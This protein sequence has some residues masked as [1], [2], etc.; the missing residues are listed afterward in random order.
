MK[1][2]STFTIVI[3]TCYVLGFYPLEGQKSVK[4]EYNI[5]EA[6][7][8]YLTTSK[9]IQ[10]MDING[11]PMQANVF[12]SLGCTI[13]Q[14]GRQD[15]NL[16]LEVKIDTLSQR[17]ESPQGNMG[18]VI[19]E[20]FGKTFT[21]T[22]TP[23]GKETDISEAAK[24]VFN[25]EGSGQSDLSQSF[26]DYFPDIPSVAMAPGY[27]WT[28]TDTVNAKTP[29]MTMIMVVK[30]ENK[31]EG[32]ETSGGK[33][34]VKI[35]SIVSGSRDMKITAQGNDI[36]MTGPF[37]GTGLLLFSTSDGYFIKHAVKTR[38]NGTLDITYPDSM[39]FPLVQD[40]DVVNEV[41]F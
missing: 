40:M 1:K 3:L 13:K 19:T 17:T 27:T 22:I 20:V 11:Q 30:A 10:T 8:K 38:L 26:Y 31:Y 21:M 15:G 33:E 25:V 18:G 36:R 16:K 29:A 23:S 6:G 28:T 4:I 41:V 35:T 5:P 37:T 24:I 39:T 7:I 9:I 14:T 2:K 32:M 12:S 34:C